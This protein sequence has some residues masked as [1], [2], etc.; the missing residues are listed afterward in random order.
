VRVHL[1][2][3]SRKQIGASAIK[4][5]CIGLA[6]MTLMCAKEHAQAIWSLCHAGTTSIS[7]IKPYI[8]LKN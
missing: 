8:F 1:S 6:A 2:I 5:W 3:S 7:K 4:S